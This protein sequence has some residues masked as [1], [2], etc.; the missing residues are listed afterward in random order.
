[1]DLRTMRFS[2]LFIAPLMVLALGLSSC[3]T[4]SDSGPETPVT[5][6]TPERS[7]DAAAETANAQE[8][9][10]NA[11][12]QSTI[13]IIATDLVSSLVQLTELS[14]FSTTIQVNRPVSDFGDEL[15]S[16]LR[17][18]GYGVQ[19]VTDDQGL[20][21]LNYFSSFSEEDEGTYYTFK[22]L[23]RDISISRSFIE[24]EGSFVPSSPVRIKGV[25]AQRIIVNDDLFRQKIGDA[26]FPSGVTFVDSNGRL[27]YHDQRT[28]VSTDAMKRNE[29]DQMKT[30]IA[31]VHARAN[32]FTKSRITATEKRTYEPIK[33]V[34]LRF[35][36][37][38][39]DLGS[40]NKTAIAQLLESFDASTDRLSITAC[41]FGKSLIWDG[42]ESIS[43]ERGLRVRQELLSSNISIDNTRDESCFSTKYGDELPRRTVILTL[44]RAMRIL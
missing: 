1:M 13:G 15:V 42:T 9:I 31:L 14:P 19:I 22:L 36:P 41:S 30:E 8:P 21:Y 16:A 37:K 24:N 35:K 28:V 7:G 26:E 20:N 23:V 5:P 32:V 25:E 17:Y 10:G 33:Q 11:P 44:E 12:S 38:S 3:A 40:N 2:V 4:N 34:S 39:L 18:S 27:I 29:N 6:E 43:L